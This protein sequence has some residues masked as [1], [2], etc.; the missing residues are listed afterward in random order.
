MSSPLSH[1]SF[2]H[3]KLIFFM[4]EGPFLPSAQEGRR[5]LPRG[6]SSSSQQPCLGPPDSVLV[7]SHFLPG[8]VEDVDDDQTCQDGDTFWLKGGYLKA[9][10]D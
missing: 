10:D 5:D 4:K 3:V 2:S 1:G 9:R 6:G 7:K 8:R